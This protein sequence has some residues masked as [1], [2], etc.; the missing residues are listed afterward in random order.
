MHNFIMLFMAEKTSIT[1][2]FRFLL[3]IIAQLFHAPCGKETFNH[4]VVSVF[5]NFHKVS[6]DLHANIY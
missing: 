3:T 2:T 6:V 1:C 4:L 5:L